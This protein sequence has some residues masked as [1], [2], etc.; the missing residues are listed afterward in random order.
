MQYLPRPEVGTRIGKELSKLLMALALI[1]RKHQPG[2][3]ELAVVRRV[4]DDCLPPNR[5]AVLRAVRR[6]KEPPTEGEI[7]QA[8]GN[9]PR[10]TLTRVLD[11]LGLL[12]VL[13]WSGPDDEERCKIAD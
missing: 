6:A 11:D 2:E 1:R 5:S 7:E 12:G 3:P 13:K 10:S 9:L 8:V 4:A